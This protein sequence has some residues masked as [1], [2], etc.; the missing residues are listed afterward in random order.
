MTPFT[1]QQLDILYMIND[2]YNEALKSLKEQYECSELNLRTIQNRDN[3]KIIL[4]ITP[5]NL[6]FQ[7]R[8]TLSK[9][10]DKTDLIRFDLFQKTQGKEVTDFTSYYKYDPSNNEIRHVYKYKSLTPRSPVIISSKQIK[11]VPIVNIYIELKKYILLNFITESDKGDIDMIKKKLNDLLNNKELPEESM[12]KIDS[13]LRMVIRMPYGHKKGENKTLG[14]ILTDTQLKIDYDSFLRYV[15]KTN[16]KLQSES[17]IETTLTDKQKKKL[18]TESLQSSSD[19]NTQK[20][21]VYQIES[22]LDVDKQ[23]YY[24]F[25][26]TT[27]N[28]YTNLLVTRYAQYYDDPDVDIT[29]SSFKFRTKMQIINKNNTKEKKTDLMHHT[30]RIRDYIDFINPDN[31]NQR[32]IVPFTITDLFFFKSTDRKEGFEKYSLMD[33]ENMKRT[34]YLMELAKSIIMT[35]VSIRT[36]IFEDIKTPGSVINYSIDLCN[37]YPS[38]CWVKDPT[39]AEIKKNIHPL[40][41]SK[42]YISNSKSKSDIIQIPFIKT[43]EIPFIDFNLPIEERTFNILQPINTKIDYGLSN[44]VRIYTEKLKPEYFNINDPRSTAFEKDIINN[45]LSND[46]ISTRKDLFFTKRLFNYAMKLEPEKE[47]T[48]VN[49]E[50]TFDIESFPLLDSHKGK[51]KKSEGVTSQSNSIKQVSTINDI[52]PEKIKT[53]DIKQTVSTTLPSPK[54][55]YTLTE[56]IIINNNIGTFLEKNDFTEVLD[57]I[58]KYLELLITNAF[59][60]FPDSIKNRYISRM[61]AGAINYIEER[62]DKEEKK[63]ELV[64]K[65]RKSYY[66]NNIYLEDNFIYS[67]FKENF[68]Q[69]RLYYSLLVEMKKEYEAIEIYKRKIEAVLKSNDFSNIND[70]INRV[71]EIL[72]QFLQY[73]E[74]YIKKSRR[75]DDRYTL[76]SPKHQTRIDKLL[77]KFEMI[78]K[79]MMR[80]DEYLNDII[81]RQIFPNISPSVFSIIPDLDIVTEI[82]QP[83]HNIQV[84]ANERARFKNGLFHSIIKKELEAHPSNSGNFLAAVIKSIEDNYEDIKVEFGGMIENNKQKKKIINDRINKRKDPTIISVTL[85]EEIA[86]I[87]TSVVSFYKDYE[88]YNVKEGDEGKL[89]YIYDPFVKSLGKSDIMKKYAREWIETKLKN[90]SERGVKTGPKVSTG[91]RKIKTT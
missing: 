55:V 38:L 35:L 7:I 24:D 90:L 78:N 59:S 37:I 85:V 44:H 2:S 72:S 41:L 16:A 88:L 61:G 9:H 6:P 47:K 36:K 52:I 27:N 49:N 81:L 43:I 68:E 40:V 91:T 20:T 71:K 3:I 5:N 32:L 19:I 84:P 77:E 75:A 66:N 82:I 48:I 15:A 8:S 33:T 10:I 14:E 39:D 28:W 29:K 18:P 87:I 21:G 62:K 22:I 54:R 70:D 46:K 65:I 60:V 79:D 80:I 31:L 73:K 69:A 26:Y 56:V 23:L 51:S 12:K 76:I 17:K 45:E 13:I 58:K 30:G 53:K 1:P 25:E 57:K 64:N 50:I 74:E 42:L 4:D 63:K 86:N 67:R 34:F 89:N 11:E 83:V